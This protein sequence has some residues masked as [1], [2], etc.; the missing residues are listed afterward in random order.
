MEMS[1]E[2]PCVAI[3]N[4]QKHHFFSFA[5]L[6]NK[7][8]EWV[9]SEG[10]GISGR[11][12]VVGKVY[13]RVNIVQIPCTQYVNGNWYLLKLFQEWEWGDKEDGGGCEFKYYIL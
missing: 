4:K 12:E 1:H 10:F 6:D 13:R 7:R 11:G 3:L 9:L 2:T 5:K 8:A